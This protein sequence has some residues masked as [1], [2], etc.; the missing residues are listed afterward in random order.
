MMQPSKLFRIRD[1]DPNPLVIPGAL[2]L[3]VTGVAFLAWTGWLIGYDAA[4]WGESFGQILLDSRVGEAMSLGIGLRGIHYLLVGAVLLPTGLVVSVIESVKSL[5]ITEGTHEIEY[6]EATAA[7][8]SQ[9]NVRI[10]IVV[11]NHGVVP[12]TLRE[13]DVGLVFGGVKAYSLFFQ[14]EG[15]TVLP[16]S[17]RDFVVGCRVVGEDADALYPATEYQTRLRLQ[18]DA[19]AVLYRTPFIHEAEGMLRMVP[20]NAEDPQA[21]AH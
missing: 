7:A 8:L 13:M 21:V 16:R 2:L 9:L 4:R 17:E 19:S 3:T 5:R 12:V 1:E 18:G 15:F 20:A 10:T 11:V 6:L 14:D